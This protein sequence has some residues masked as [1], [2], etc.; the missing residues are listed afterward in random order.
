V[1][2]SKSTAF[3]FS[4]ERQEEDLQAIVFARGLNGDIRDSVAAP[5]RNT[6][7]SLRVSHRF[8][9]NHSVSW[10]YN[11][12]EFPST[13]PGVGGVVLA[14]AG[15]TVRPA[16]REVI[17]NDQRTLPPHWV[18]QL[19]ILIGR[20]REES[21]S[22]SS[23]PKIVVQDAFTAGGGQVNLL[24]T[25]N[26]AQMNDI[27]NW[28]SGKHLVKAGINVPDWSRR[29][30]NDRNNFGGTFFFASLADYAARRPY[31]GRL[32]C[33]GGACAVWNVRRVRDPLRSDRDHVLDRDGRRN[34]GRAR[35]AV[36]SVARRRQHL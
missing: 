1:G 35:E 30:F 16:E 24:R 19:Q 7:V 23:A 14:E 33:T 9:A 26:H 36:G 20:E 4:G 13:N 22:A 21:A 28:S 11:D 27:V 29:G 5:K 10:Q 8:S 2:H 15:T 32:Q 6:Q 12:R 17:F 25:E 34:R 18:N 31:A 3:L